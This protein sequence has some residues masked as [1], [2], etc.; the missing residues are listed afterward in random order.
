[1]AKKTDPEVLGDT[2]PTITL[3]SGQEIRVLPLRTRQ[4]F[5]FMRILTRDGLPKLLNLDLDTEASGEKFMFQL[6]GLV[7]TSVF[8]AEDETIDFIKAVVEPVGL[9][10]NPKDKAAQKHNENL[11]L[12]MFDELE[13]PD[14]QD[15]LSILEKLV[16][17]EAGDIQ[18][19]GKRFVSVVKM[20]A[21]MAQSNLP[22]QDP[23]GTPLQTSTQTESSEDSAE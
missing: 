8:E 14:P 23:Q 19:L 1:M 20:A 2:G 11:F 13:N 5:A 10:K 6:L 21:K 9:K 7:V 12:E 16:E 15:L 18:A 4:L 22:K 17:E 3:V